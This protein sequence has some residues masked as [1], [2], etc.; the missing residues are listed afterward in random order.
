MLVPIS[1]GGFGVRE[2]GFVILLG[3][4]GISATDA[5]LLSLLS[6][7]VIVLASVVTL[8]PLSAGPNLFQTPPARMRESGG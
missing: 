8:A 4:A 1:I 3:E 6:A 7:M 5:T 2:A